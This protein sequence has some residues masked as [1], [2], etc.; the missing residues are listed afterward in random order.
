MTK[1]RQRLPTEP[2]NVFGGNPFETLGSEGLSSLPKSKQENSD[3]KVIFSNTER[4][5]K[6][7]RIEVRREKSG[8]G[9]KTVTTIRGFPVRISHDDLNR[10]LK[11]LKSSLG[12][13]GGWRNDQLEIQGDQRELVCEWLSSM[14]FKPVLAGG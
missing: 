14:G 1:K 5:G 3:T 2:S 13:G 7:E 11:R 6:G 4:M 8:R 12:T 9:G 10:A